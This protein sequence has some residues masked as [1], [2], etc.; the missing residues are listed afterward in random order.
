M[1]LRQRRFLPPLPVV[2]SLILVLR[3]LVLQ[4]G[5][6]IGGHRT[7]P[8]PGNGATWGAHSVWQGRE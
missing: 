1:A 8:G 6:A 7:A 2:L 4:A 3:R 5:R